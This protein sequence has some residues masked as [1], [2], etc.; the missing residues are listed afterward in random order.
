MRLRVDEVLAA[1]GGSLARPEARA[2]SVVISGVSTDTRTLRPGD[3]FVPLRGPHADGHD[4]IAEA[5]RRGAGAALSSRPLAG[6]VGPVIQV[7][8]CARALADLA[9]AYRAAMPVRVVG[10]TG[11]VGKTTTAAMVAAVLGVRLRVLR[12]P[13]EWNA[14]IGVPLTLLGLGPEHEVAVIEMAMRGSGQIADL[15]ALARPELGVVTT[16]GASHLGLL[17]TL[18][19]VARAKGELVEGLPAHGT[20]VLNRDDSRVHALAPRSRARVLTYGLHPEADVRA[21][22]IETTEPGMR[23][24]IVTQ[25]QRHDVALATWGLHNVRNALAAA[26]VARALGVDPEAVREG[27]ATF[28]PPTMRLQPVAAGDVLIIN[29]AYNASPASMEAAFDVLAEVGRGRR[30]VAALGEMQELGAGAIQMHRDVGSSLA[31]HAVALLVAVE[32]GGEAIAAGAE[33]A[34]MARDRI[35]RARS[36]EEAADRLLN[37]VRPGDV[38]LVKGSRALQMERLVDALLRKVRP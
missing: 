4:F 12:T 31:R 10:V 14:E 6:A 15:V 36:V 1:T 24:K 23:F 11:S 18:E 7:A 22:D 3:L 37:L 29:D 13:D 27:L 5:F 32:P 16:I 38:V 35:V 9:R 25:G 26:A 33:A 28:R 2:A 21:V 19:A 8:E 30:L 17:G 20:A 34:G